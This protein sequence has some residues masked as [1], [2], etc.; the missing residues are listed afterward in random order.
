[1]SKISR[2][3]AVP[4]MLKVPQCTSSKDNVRY[5]GNKTLADLQINEY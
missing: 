5:Y 4:S 2:F 1:M 3:L